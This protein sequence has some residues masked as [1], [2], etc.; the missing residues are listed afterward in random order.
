ML[1]LHTSLYTD[2]VEHSAYNVMHKKTFY[3]LLN[4]SGLLM[5]ESQNLSSYSGTVPHS[6]NVPHHH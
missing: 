4:K 2:V 1:H 5:K 3:D 6:H